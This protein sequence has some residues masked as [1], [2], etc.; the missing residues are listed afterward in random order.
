MKKEQLDQVVLRKLKIEDYAETDLAQWE[1]FLYK[2]KNPSSRTKIGLVGKYV[3]LKDAYKSIAEAIIHAGVQ[4]SCKVDVEW[5]H[6]EDIDA[7]NEAELHRTLGQLNGILVAPG[8]GSRGIEGK[9][10]TIQYAR[11]HHVPFLGICLGMQCAVIEYA[12]NVLGWEDANSTEFNASTSY[13]VIDFM[14]GQNEDMHKGGTMRLGSYDCKVMENSLGMNIYGAGMIKERHRHRYEF[15]NSFLPEFESKGMIASGIN[16][17]NSLVEMVEIPAHP[18]FVGVQFH[19]EYKSTVANPHP[20]FVK[21]I[22][23]ALTVRKE[24][25]KTSA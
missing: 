21:F 1:D 14:E 19:P 4:N 12:R 15:N 25:V 6:S 23:A 17:E 3:E 11:E 16:P 2:L 7:M 22:K 24:S 5:I 9:I 10:R 8:F 18:W 20:L 13:P